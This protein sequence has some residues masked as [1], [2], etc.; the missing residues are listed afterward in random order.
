MLKQFIITALAALFLAGV[1][2]PFNT[3]TNAQ[4]GEEKPIEDGTNDEFTFEESP[5]KDNITA[6]EFPG[7]ICGQEFEDFTIVCFGDV[8]ETTVVDENGTVQEEVPVATVEE[9]VQGFVDHAESDIEQAV[10]ILEDNG[11]EAVGT[12]NLTIVE[13]TPAVN[14]TVPPVVNE[15]VTPVVNET[16]TPV[17]NQT[18]TPVVNVTEPTPVEE[19]MVVPTPTPVENVTV[20]ENVTTPANTTEVIVIGEGN[21][22]DPIVEGNVTD[23][24]VVIPDNETVTIPENTTEVV[25]VI[26]NQT[27]VIEEAT[28]NVTSTDNEDTTETENVLSTEVQEGLLVLFQVQAER[29]DFDQLSEDQVNTIEDAIDSL[30]GAIDEAVNVLSE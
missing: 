20:T 8:F 9:Q 24:V 1:I 26:N 21:V 7:Q 13:E 19:P 3:V 25:E 16:V 10:T 23:P 30:S 18:E 17:V 28:D 29:A 5:P 4:E 14:E 15:T 6:E 22:T 11:I 27:D 12:V 2:V